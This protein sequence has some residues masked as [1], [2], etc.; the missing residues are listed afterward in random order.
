M[1]T[2]TRGLDTYAAL[3][4]DMSKAYDQVEWEFMKKMLSK[5]GSQ[6]GWVKTLMN[7]VTTVRYQIC[8]NGELSDEI[9]PQRGLRQGDPL[10]PYLF[11]ICVETFSFL[12]NEAERHGETT[13]IRV[14]QDAPSINHLLFADDSLLLFKIDARSAEYSI[15]VRG[16]LGANNQQ[17]QVIY[18]V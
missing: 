13:G 12:L 17:G 4:L 2:K 3:K 18:H 16:F 9:A 6:E 1:Q 8:V 5:L 14:C 15:I 10:S 11:L 7:L